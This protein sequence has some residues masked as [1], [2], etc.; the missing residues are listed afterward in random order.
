MTAESQQHCD[1]MEVPLEVNVMAQGYPLVENLVG[2]AVSFENE[3][4]LDFVGYEDALGNRVELNSHE[5][6][7]FKRAAYSALMKEAGKEWVLTE[8]REAFWHHQS[9]KR[10]AAQERA[11]EFRSSV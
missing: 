3:S 4:R 8:F 7:G 1:C 10:I 2:F 11:A 5:L 9:G 6:D